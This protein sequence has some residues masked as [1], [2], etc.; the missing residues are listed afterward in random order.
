MSLDKAIKHGKEHRRTYSEKGRRSGD[1]VRSCRNSGSC[2]YCR[3]N[4]LRHHY[5]EQ[6]IVE[7]EEVVND[8][9]EEDYWKFLEERWELDEYEQQ[10]Y[11]S[12][13]LDDKHK[14]G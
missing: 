7:Q 6:V 14:I 8:P 12:I 10:V 2:E 5:R 9:T 4:R 11:N 1:M 13:V 3:R